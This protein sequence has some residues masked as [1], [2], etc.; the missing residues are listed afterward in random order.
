VT[1]LLYASFF[2]IQR[3]RGWKG[4]GGTERQ[5]KEERINRLIFC[6]FL[7]RERERENKQ[8]YLPCFLK[9]EKSKRERRRRRGMV[10]H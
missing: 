5:R 2:Y 1:I 3:R 8:T 6:V 7:K 9:K 4:V 10:Q